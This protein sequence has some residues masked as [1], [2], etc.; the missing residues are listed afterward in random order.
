MTLLTRT[1]A[2]QHLIGHAVGHV[3]HDAVGYALHHRFHVSHHR[4][5][6][7][8]AHAVH[9]A[10]G[11][12]MDD[13]EGRTLMSAAAMAHADLPLV[14]RAKPVVVVTPSRTPATVAV[15]ST[16][17]TA[18]ADP[19]TT[20]PSFA[21]K[22]FASD[23]LFGPAGPSVNDVSQGEL[24]DCYLLAVLSSVAKSDAGLIR[25]LV[26]ANANGTYTVTFGGAKAAA[27]VTVDAELPTLS[28]GQPAY[29][30][31]GGGG[32]IW[33]PIVEKAYADYA[34]PKADSY[35][36]ISGGWMGDA[37]T[38]LGL[39]SAGAFSAASAAAL[40]TLVQKDLKAGD[41]VTMGTASAV[42]PKS[43]LVAGH[44]YEIDSVT[45][46]KRGNVTAV[47]V[48]NPWGNDVANGGYVTVTPA[49]AY[50]AFAGLSVSHA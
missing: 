27:A 48:R 26:T 38:A 23:P 16:G 25:H 20:D 11:A 46:D 12:T 37:F 7:H 41:F 1:H 18:V 47:T 15:P 3:V 35:T 9:S 14:V 39:K 24:G 29:A 42:G 34:S 13:L 30:Q 28:D 44:A 19:V 21:Y 36:T 4:H 31:L 2:V 17:P 33:V 10:D 40:A 45:L 49:Q 5:P 50:A 22:S 32:S 43:P 8:H 6:N